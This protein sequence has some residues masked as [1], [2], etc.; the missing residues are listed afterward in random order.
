MYGVGAYGTVPYG[1]GPIIITVSPERDALF[2]ASQA[3]TAWVSLVAH[4]IWL[5]PTGGLMPTSISS[6]ATDYVYVPITA[7]LPDG[8]VI[9]PTGD[10]V[11]FTFLGS[12]DS[13]V[14]TTPWYTASWAAGTPYTAQ[15]LVGPGGGVLSLVA[16][17]SAYT[18]WVKIFDSPET[19]ILFAGRLQ[20]T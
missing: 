12:S 15:C 10:T 2:I 5:T 4:T 8:T 17:A 11:Q 13:P 9:D 16:T 3:F 1:I 19:P 20:V 7:T 14:S 18:V 6:Q